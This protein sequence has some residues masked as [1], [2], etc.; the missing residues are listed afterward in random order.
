MLD[1]CND[2]NA[3]GLEEFMILKGTGH[4]ACS[5]GIPATYY[6]SLSVKDSTLKKNGPL[7]KL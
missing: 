4:Y 7:S 1:E 3:T 2:L 6:S 5:R